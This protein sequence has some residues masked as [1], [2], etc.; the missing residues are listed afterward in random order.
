MFT[1]RTGSFPDPYRIPDQFLHFA[2]DFFIVLQCFNI[3]TDG[4]TE[5]TPS[6]DTFGR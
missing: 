4:K 2:K 5:V 6:G 1:R 3:S